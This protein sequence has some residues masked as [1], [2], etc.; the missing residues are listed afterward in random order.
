MRCCC[1]LTGSCL[2][3]ESTLS[4]QSRRIWNQSQ[5]LEYIWFIQKPCLFFT[6]L[7]PDASSLKAVLSWCYSLGSLCLLLEALLPTPEVLLCE[8]L[9]FDVSW[10]Q[11]Q[12]FHCCSEVMKNK[13]NLCQYSGLSVSYETIKQQYFLSSDF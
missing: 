11:K 8:K 1:Q 3:R 10:L 7:F 5:L 2:L 9:N 4:S 13:C 12:M 6:Q